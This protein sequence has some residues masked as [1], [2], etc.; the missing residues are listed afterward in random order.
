MP[1]AAQRSTQTAILRQLAEVVTVAA[2]AADDRVDSRD[3]LVLPP[4]AVDEV[5]R[6]PALFS[7]R[8]HLVHH[9]DPFSWQ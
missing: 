5:H 4:V 6:F 8:R 1:R 9:G 7:L 2:S 3:E